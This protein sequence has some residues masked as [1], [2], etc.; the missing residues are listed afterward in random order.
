[1]VTGEWLDSWTGVIFCFGVFQLTEG[2]RK[3]SEESA[4]FP[5]VRVS[6]STL[7]CF[8]RPKRRTNSACEGYP[9]LTCSEESL[10]IKV[11]RECAF[12]MWIKKLVLLLPIISVEKAFAV[13]RRSESTRPRTQGHT[14]VY[15]K[16][17]KTEKNFNFQK[18]P[19]TCRRGLASVSQLRRGI[20]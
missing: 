14:C 18:Y 5:A 2:K 6:C 7:S 8:V 16:L 1:M 12:L 19:D 10:C 11:D 15:A 17:P 9:F 20:Q 13:K 4:P 3:K